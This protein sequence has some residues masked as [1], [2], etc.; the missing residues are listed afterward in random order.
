MAYH[1]QIARQDLEYLESRPH[2]SPAKLA[3][4][5]A[6]I[7]DCLGNVT[8]EF[9]ETG[10]LSPGSPHFLFDYIFLDGS[11]A[12]QLLFYVN[13]SH[14]AAGVLVI[15]FVDLKLAVQLAM[16]DSAF[17][18]N[19]CKQSLGSQMVPVSAVAATV[20]GLAR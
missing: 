20:K 9:R 18:T 15:A 11:H 4:V 8:D 3:E 5:L 2:I 7:W 6:D 17:L 12:H 13:D 16:D 1:V 14:A 10:R 19:H